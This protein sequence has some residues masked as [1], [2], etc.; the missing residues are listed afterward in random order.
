MENPGSLLKKDKRICF[1]V[2]SIGEKGGTERVATLIANGLNR[3]GYDVSILSLWGGLTSSYALDPDVS[4]HELFSENRKFKWKYLEIVRELRKY[5]KDNK[6]NILVSTDTILTLYSVPACV[7][8]KVLQIAWEHFNFY[9]SLDLKARKFS[10]YF[11]AR[12]VNTVVV[13]TEEDL[14]TWNRKVSGKA[15]I[16]AISNPITFPPIDPQGRNWDSKLAIAAGRLTY[17]K[18]FDLLVRSWEKVAQLAPDWKLY[19]VG[20]GEDE[21]ALRGQ[22]QSLGLDN[23]VSIIPFSEHIA[24]YFLQAS[25][26][27]LSSRFEGLPMVL[28]EAQAF[29]LPSVCFNCYTGPAEVVI[30]DENG[31]IVPENDFA[32]FSD[33]II[34]L[35]QDTALRERLGRNALKRAERYQ[36]ASILD[37]WETLLE[38]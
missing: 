5:L 1:F 19:I 20:S 7:R 38:S 8:R 23:V 4:L 26:F 6:I 32:G 14:K 16:V 12:M 21:S 11:A 9:A 34:A 27:C 10:R 36:E 25:V 13:L 28:L 35:A 33:R 24:E 31:Y 30:P 18:G 15:R 2:G 29:G 3:R 37:Q 22:I 17:Q